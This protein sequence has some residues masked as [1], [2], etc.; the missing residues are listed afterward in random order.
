[1]PSSSLLLL[2]TVPNCLLDGKGNVMLGIC[3]LLSRRYI[4]LGCLQRRANKEMAQQS[5]GAMDG[6]R[7]PS[8]AKPIPSEEL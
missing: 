2:L 7:S 1:M 6:T 3:S 4:F 8:T 5:K